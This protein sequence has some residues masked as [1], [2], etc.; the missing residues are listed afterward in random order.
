MS[1][2]NLAGMPWRFYTNLS[3]TRDMWQDVIGGLR[4][5]LHALHYLGGGS[6]YRGGP[7]PCYDGCTARCKSLRAQL[8]IARE[9]YRGTFEHG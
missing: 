5:E 9:R 2:I 4:A 7:K 6:Q 3:S 8:E 1:R